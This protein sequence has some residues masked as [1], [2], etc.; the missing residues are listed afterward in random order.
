MNR[1]WGF[2]LLIA[3][4]IPGLGSC[5]S[6][7]KTEDKNISPYQEETPTLK[8]TVTQAPTQNS[9]EQPTEKPE[10]TTQEANLRFIVLADSRGLDLGVNS[11]I[12][13]KVLSQVKQLSPQPEFAIL[14]GDLTE[15]SKS[16]T[17]VQDQ[18]DYFKEIITQYY[19]VGFYYPGI[20][21]H[22]MRAGEGG[23]KAFSKTFSE[24]VADFLEG[25]NRT[26]YYFDA[27]D[28]RFFMLN[29]DHPDEKHKITGDQL[30]WLKD[31]IDPDKK[32]NIFLM[33]EPPYPTGSEAGNSLD[34]FPA[35]RDVFWKVVDQTPGAIVF[36][37]HEHNYSR[38]L[39]DSSFN[40]TIGKKSYEFGSEVYQIITGGFGA[41][42]YT[43]YSS[44]KNI[45]IPP[46]PQYHFTVVDINDSGVNIQA[47]NIDGEII[48]S[49][50]VK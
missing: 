23:E 21:N 24:F 31:N 26:S 1:K 37:G 10:N 34:R 20:G 30:I 50:Q 40:E 13:K 15:G 47:I 43:K 42:L 12:V 14:P 33:H 38:R 4:I 8:P 19:P 11:E 49:F 18:L 41:P 44:K 45:I 9:T 35:A 36:C 27:G 5:N 22:E 25:Y 16:Y 3:V 7:N 29:S 32:H 17:E 2:V 28:T 6:G 46:V 39:I 48:D